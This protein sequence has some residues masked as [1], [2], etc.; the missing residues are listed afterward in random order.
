MEELLRE[1]A[2]AL[3]WDEDEDADDL[4]EFQAV[5]DEEAERWIDRAR[6]LLEV[7]SSIFVEGFD[8]NL[9]SWARED[10]DPGDPWGWVMSWLF[11]IAGELAL[12]GEEVPP[13]LEYHPGLFGAEVQRQGLDEFPTEELQRAARI[14]HRYALLCQ[15][16]GRDY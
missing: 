12:R 6:K 3:K 4:R 16:F 13:E 15:H 1:I 8:F 14:L 2:R 10:R 9:L 11:D 5:R 7:K